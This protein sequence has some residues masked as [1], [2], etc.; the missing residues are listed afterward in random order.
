MRCNSGIS[1]T[2]IETLTLNASAVQQSNTYSAR[3]SPVSLRNVFVGY[4]LQ[5][6]FSNNLAY[7]Y[8]GVINI[9]NSTLDINHSLFHDNYVNYVGGVIYVHDNY[10]RPPVRRVINITIVNSTFTSNRVR[11]IGE[12]GVVYV[13]DRQGNYYP[14]SITLTILNCSFINNYA[15]YHGGV[16]YYQGYKTVT[17]TNCAFTNNRVTRN[18]K[19]GG[20]IYS[21]AP[22]ELT[23]NTFSGN[24]ATGTGGAIYCTSELLSLDNNFVKNS[25]V[26]GGAIYITST[27][28]VVRSEFTSNTAQNFGGSIHIT[29]TSSSISVLQSSFTNNTALTLG[30]GAIYAHSRYSNISIS[31]S[32][33]TLNSASYCSVLDVDEFYHF[34]V[35]IT[36]SSFTHNTATGR[37]LGGGVACIR[38]SSIDILRSSFQHNHADLHGGVFQID[39]SDVFVEDSVFVNNSAGVDGGVFYTYVHP[40]LYLIRRSEFSSNTAREDGGVMF[41]GRVTSQVSIEECSFSF[42]DALVR[43]GVAALI[44]TSMTLELNWTSIFNNTAQFGGIISSCNSEVTV[45]GD[46]LF[47]SSDP[48]NAICTLYDG[49]IVN[50]QIPHPVNPNTTTPIPETT[51]P[52]PDTSTP[53]S[54]TLTPTPN[55]STPIPDTS[56]PT[57]DT[58]TPTP[59]TSTPIPDTTQHLIITS[60]TLTQLASPSSDVS[61]TSS[62]TLSNIL[63]NSMTSVVGD[64]MQTRVSVMSTAVSAMVD[65][66]SSTDEATTSFTAPRISPSQSA[67]PETLMSFLIEIPTSYSIYQEEVTTSLK[68][69]SNFPSVSTDIYSDKI[70][71]TRGTEYMY[72]QISEIAHHTPSPM[73]ITSSVYSGDVM[74]ATSLKVSSSSDKLRLF[75]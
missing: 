43:G 51:T 34:N 65:L 7:Q 37:L 23:N 72:S 35:S 39:E 2:D 19:H 62:I 18:T 16:L 15:G 60:S 29:G 38:N 27:S 20:A 24:Q 10:E 25:A 71:P 41:V 22:L 50:Y 75:L 58:L 67:A 63:V 4:C 74:R 52:I 56:T 48:V 31:A 44:G 36:N 21:T 14:P 47:I 70:T 54:D 45:V 46:E 55:T 17:I 33:F 13:I 69:T 73:T 6:V 32:T 9:R 28:T 8:G 11:Y 1:F 57:S 68:T 66:T 40:S 59:N 5:S 30:G 61:M 49:H 3:V 42:N 12:G 53:T 26:D 64:F